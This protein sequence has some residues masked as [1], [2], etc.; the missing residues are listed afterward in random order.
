MIIENVKLNK[1]YDSRGQETLEVIL[2][3]NGINAVSQV[4]QGKS[5]GANE[6]ISLEYQKAKEVLENSVKAEI[7]SHDF[8]NIEN[9]DNFL[10]RLDGT[11]NKS[12]LGGNLMLGLSLSFA[13]LLAQN[14]HKELWQILREGFFPGVKENPIPKIFAN[15]INGGV[16][17]DNNLSFQEYMA[18]S[19]EE[20]DANKVV[21]DMLSCYEKLKSY[22]KQTRNIRNVPIG[23]EAGFSLEFKNNEEPL[24]VLEDIIKQNN[25]NFKIALDVAASSFFKDGNYSIDGSKMNKKELLNYHSSL[26]E[27]H[28]LLYSIEDPF[29][30][31]DF[32]SFKNLKENISSE[33]LVVGDDLT[34]T[35]PKIIQ[36]ANEQN[37]I[38]AVIIKANQIGTLSETARAIQKADGFNFKTIISHRSGETRDNF[39]MHIAKASNAYGIKIGSPKRERILK[40]DEFLR[41]Y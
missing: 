29:E 36:K 23:D 8:G 3:A 15:L 12:R 25:H 28:P 26:F 37:S 21:V 13:R 16:H 6:V 38:N 9:F 1:I 20:N 27:K 4:P 22:F 40:Y 24:Y 7:L 5:K 41:F 2:Y 14:E 33:N 31:S 34:T 39:L 30:E 19:Q 18:V 10:I 35:N 11:E 17:A 32:E